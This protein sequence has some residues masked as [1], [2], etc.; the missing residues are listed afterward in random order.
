MLLKTPGAK[1]ADSTRGLLH[2]LLAATTLLLAGCAD[3]YRPLVDEKQA[4]GSTNLPT[5]AI[6]LDLA[7]AQAVK[8]PF[9]LG[10][11]PAA[12]RGTALMLP[13]ATRAAT[14]NV[15]ATL[16]LEVRQPG[17][18]HVWVSALWR[19]ACRNSITV[20]L[21]DHPGYAAGQDAVYSAWHWVRAGTVELSAGRHTA[22]IAGREDGVAVDQLF[23]TRDPAF[24]PVLA[25]RM[26][27]RGQQIQRFGDDF[28][29]SP[30]HGLANWDLRSGDWRIVF[31]FDPNRI[32]NQYALHGTATNG[33]AVALIRDMPW[34]GCRFAFSMRPTTN[35]HSGAVLDSSVDG[36]Q[37]LRV[38]IEL[39]GNGASLHVRGNGLDI[40]KD[41]TAAVRLQ[42][43]HRIVIERWAW[44]TSVSIDGNDM[45][46]HYDTKAGAGR[47]GFF[48][49]SGEAVFDDV[50]LEEI[51][52]LADNGREFTMHWTP[53]AGAQWFRP[54]VTNL[55]EALMGRKGA[56]S[57]DWPGRV[58]DEV[59]VEDVP[60]PSGNRPA[61]VTGFDQASGAGGFRTLRRSAAGSRQ[62]S[63]LSLEAG[64]KQSSIRRIAARCANVTPDLALI[65]PYQF[66][67]P[68]IEDASDYLDFTPEEYREIQQS[69][70]VQKLRREVKFKPVLGRGDDYSPWEIQRGAWTLQDKSLAG[71]GP[72]AL[73]RHSQDIAGDFEAR[74]RIRLVL[75]NSVAEVGLHMSDDSRQCVRI[76]ADRNPPG[77]ITNTI[78]LAAST[79]AWHVLR[80]RA[81]RDR[82]FAG[83][84]DRPFE[85][86]ATPGMTGGRILLAVPS[87]QA[88]FDDIEFI[89]PRRTDSS[90]LYVFDRQETDWWREGGEWVDHG[91]IA[92]V[93]ASS[94]ISL[95]A[96]RGEGMLWN[97]RAFSSNLLVALDVQENSEWFGW[98]RNPSHVHHSFDNICIALGPA[99]DSSKGYRVELNARGRAATVLYRD[100]VEVA[101]VR[102]DHRFPMRYNG[103]HAPYTPRKN[104]ISLRK[105]GGLLVLTVN[106]R[107][108]LRYEDPSPLPVS[109][110]GI[111]GHHTH[112][113]FTWVEI[114]NL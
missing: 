63:R 43:W 47:V 91:G 56:I 101:A 2:I 3:K 90:V 89:Q 94:W 106:G 1:C 24:T 42:Q 97:K 21:D 68:N 17:K 53:D 28:A 83:L 64:E 93:Q 12:A 111:G 77:S 65:G 114:I 6:I 84:D 80:V 58:I 38:G 32:P 19:D 109:R 98:N 16:N 87:G 55:A 41:I 70:E 110:A 99:R 35:G 74:L 46:T 33:Q 45:F 44:T 108:V 9:V 92:C 59:V 29:R 8:P 69:P 18:Y 71:L 4:A 66:G 40:R 27:G 10:P 11:H 85:E 75:S 13:D 15:S 31:G 20:R 51:L 14:A 100:G 67:E 79:G 86:L 39:T 81:D 25:S 104:R 30:G 23:L 49:D 34:N 82:L 72:G 88:Q 61:G 112:I 78:S 105:Q 96:P 54:A 52:W 50:A 76:A 103:G 5:D 62:G 60:D 107:D 95:Q 102:Q 26:L 73:L 48:V 113:N 22:A 7:D 37:A 57:S 36:S